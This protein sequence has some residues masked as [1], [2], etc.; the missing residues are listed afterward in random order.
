MV[1]AAV[2]AGHIASAEEPDSAA[3]GK[4]KII[5]QRYCA[6]CHGR[7]G[8]GDGI[9]AQDLVVPPPD[10]TMIAKKNNGRFPLSMVVQGIDGRQLGHGHGAPDMPVWGEVFPKTEGPE[11]ADVKSL[12]GRLAQYL[13]SI[14]R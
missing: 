13:W 7:E 5:Y 8:R 10:L 4:G 3:A 14:Q 1:V 6:S 9:L 11:G 2:S 12:V